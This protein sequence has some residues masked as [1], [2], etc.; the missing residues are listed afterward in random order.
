MGPPGYPVSAI[1]AMEEFVLPLLA[2]W[3][4]REPACRESLEVVPCNPIPSRPGMEERVRVKLGMVNGTCFAVPLPRGAG[5]VTSLSRADAVIPVERDREGLN[6][7][8]PVRAELFR[9]RREIEGALLATGSHD[10]TLDLIDSMLR[11]NHP[12]FRLTS[13]HA[14]SL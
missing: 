12:C 11:R 1:V 8:E 3:L 2:R 5:T 7:G 4:K 9:T 13:A 6:A 10:N 14:V